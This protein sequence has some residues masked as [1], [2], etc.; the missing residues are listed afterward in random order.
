M[1]KKAIDLLRGSN[2]YKIIRE[3]VDIPLDDD[4]V[5]EAYFAAPDIWSIK[6]EQE[7]V[8]AV[9]L[10]VAERRGL[11]KEKIDEAD[12]QAELDQIDDSTPEGQKARKYVASQRP[13]NLA[14]QT[15]QKMTK[16]ATIRNILPKFLYDRKTGERLFPDE[17]DQAAFTEIVAQNMEL[18]TLLAN[19]YT[20]LSTKVSA[21]KELV[22]NSTTPTNSPSGS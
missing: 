9:K 3:D 14:Q 5:I 16:F 13:L 12:F 11:A 18:F 2:R 7:L 17:D 20:R 15:A 4:K 21:D 19:A 10:K 6:E 22:K 1:S 8:Y